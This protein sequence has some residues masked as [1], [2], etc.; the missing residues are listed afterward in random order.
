ML[1]C[2]L[3]YAG[4]SNNPM[5]SPPAAAAA[6]VCSAATAAVRNYCCVRALLLI[7]HPPEGAP[8]DILPA[9]VVTLQWCCDVVQGVV[10]VGARHINTKGTPVIVGVCGSRPC[11]STHTTHH[12]AT[13]HAAL[14]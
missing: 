9:Y 12:Q 4:G 3:S 2:D 8:C 11:A 1:C 6:A 10:E 14:L 5:Q 7:H 13:L